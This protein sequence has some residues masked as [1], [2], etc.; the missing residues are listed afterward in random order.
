MQGCVRAHGKKVGRAKVSRGLETMVLLRQERQAMTSR[1][2][3]RPM[4][5][6]LAAGARGVRRLPQPL[7]P[8]ASGAPARRRS[9]RTTRPLTQARS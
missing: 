7:V 4:Q 6:A 9:P 1:Q 2:T 5:L 8:L 3:T